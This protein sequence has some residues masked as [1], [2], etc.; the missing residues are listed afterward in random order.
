MPSSNPAGG[1]MDDIIENKFLIYIS[2]IFFNFSVNLNLKIFD[3]QER[4][5]TE[6]KPAQV[7]TLGLDL[8]LLLH[9]STV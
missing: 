6:V 4:L 1:K 7:L 3:F 2:K 5:E 8:N 9:Q